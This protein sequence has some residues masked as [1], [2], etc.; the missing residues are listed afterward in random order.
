MLPEY[1]K[2]TKEKFKKK[3]DKKINFNKFLI[4]IIFIQSLLLLYCIIFWKKIRLSKYGFDNQEYCSISI[5]TIS[6]LESFYLNCE[7]FKDTTHVETYFN[8]RSL[9]PI[10]IYYYITNN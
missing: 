10:N 7:Y 9:N 8:I 5:Q 3:Q 1:S 2:D 6:M 4:S